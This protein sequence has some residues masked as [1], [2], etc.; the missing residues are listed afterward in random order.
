MY[1]T[2]KNTEHLGPYTKIIFILKIKTTL[3]KLK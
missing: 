1:I 3:K 2:E